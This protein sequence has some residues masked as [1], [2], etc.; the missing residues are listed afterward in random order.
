MND[1]YLRFEEGS[2]RLSE[3]RLTELLRTPDGFSTDMQIGGWVPRAQFPTNLI[4]DVKL[5]EAQLHTEYATFKITDVSVAVSAK[6]HGD[7]R[8]LFVKVRFL[9]NNDN[10]EEQ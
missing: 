5:I 7:K 8:G 6:G 10:N 1:G 9:H 3:C 2:L 4:G